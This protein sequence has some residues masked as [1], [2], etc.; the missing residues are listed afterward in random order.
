[1]LEKAAR[2]SGATVSAYLRNMIKDVP[3][4]DPK[5]VRAINNLVNEINYIG[6]N[7]NQIVKNNNS[8]LYSDFDKSRLLEYMRV[9]N[10]KVDT[11]IAQNG[12]Q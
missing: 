1:M 2:N 12:N 7:I 8:G 5:L 4:V 11:L 3:A 10:E 6:H 9:I